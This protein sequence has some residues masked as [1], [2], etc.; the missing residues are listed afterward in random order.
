MGFQMVVQMQN[1]IL[2]IP[3][4][5]VSMDSN[6]QHQ[7][8]PPGESSWCGWQRDQAKHTAEYKHHDSLPLPVFQCI[9][10][11]FQR[12]SKEDLL[13]KCLHGGTQ[14]RN[15]SFHNTVWSV[16]P[17]VTYKCYETFPSSVNFAVCKWNSGAMFIDDLMK[18]LGINP[19][20]HLTEMLKTED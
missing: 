8:C 15:E 18:A 16:T 5:K 10:P 4:H 6:P 9:L 17:K 3:H 11:V 20:K 14:N 1:Q 13:K 7:Y 2:V 12:L 19:R